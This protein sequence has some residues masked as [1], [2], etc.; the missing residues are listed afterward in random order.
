MGCVPTK[1]SCATGLELVTLRLGHCD[2]ANEVN[3][4]NDGNG[5]AQWMKREWLNGEYD[6][7]KH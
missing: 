5:A 7:V 4:A 6:A 2:D 1:E 3:E